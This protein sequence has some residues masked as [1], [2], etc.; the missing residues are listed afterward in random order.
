MPDP[1]APKRTVI[2]L[3]VHTVLKLQ[4]IYLTLRFQHVDHHFRWHNSSTGISPGLPASDYR[5]P[6]GGY[7]SQYCYRWNNGL[8][9]IA[10]VL[11]SKKCGHIA[12][13][14][15][16]TIAYRHIRPWSF[17]LMSIWVEQYHHLKSTHV[18][19]PRDSWL[20][21]LIKSGVSLQEW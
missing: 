1:E 21:P 11:Q 5:G 8:P 4:K 16:W 9:Y 7:D 12:T 18:K 14:Q 15:D 13:S 6:V 17:P 10:D 19:R 3:L 20:L 2:L